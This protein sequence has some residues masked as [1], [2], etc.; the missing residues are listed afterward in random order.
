MEEAILHFSSPKNKLA[1]RLVRVTRDG[2]P[3]AK[4]YT[5]PKSAA[6][7]VKVGQKRS[8]VFRFESKK[9]LMALNSAYGF[10]L[11]TSEIG[12]THDVKNA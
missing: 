8:P 6:W 4:I 7:F 1:L 12:Y 3:F 10:V 5:Y 11:E 2:V 9:K